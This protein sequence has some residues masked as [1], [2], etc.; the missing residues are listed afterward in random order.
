MSK[1][2]LSQAITTLHTPV[3][4]QVYS[5]P[6]VLGLDPNSET[7]DYTNSV[8]I[9][10]LGCVIYELLVGAQLFTSEFQLSGYFYGKWAFPENRLRGLSPPT[11][12]IGISLLKALLV[13][14]PEGR[15]TAADALAHAWLRDLKS[16]NDSSGDD[17]NKTIQSRHGSVLRRTCENR[18]STHD[19]PKMGG[20]RRSS[21]RHGDTRCI[22]RG[23]AFGPS[24]GLRDGGGPPTPS[25]K[26]IMGA[27]VITPSYTVFAGS[28]AIPTGYQKSKPIHH[29]HDLGSKGSNGLGE[30]E[31]YDIPQIGSQGMIPPPIP[32]S[33]STQSILRG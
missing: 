4:T 32:N 33:I 5:A 20:N 22:P 16:D 28:S 26:A 3:S 18:L 9:W 24:G 13:I 8:D 30:K 11:D 1:R 14:Q 2:I 23:V 25:L 31:A 12:E 21:L 7:S 27:S 6:E 15:P 19:K 10:S 29:S 17:W